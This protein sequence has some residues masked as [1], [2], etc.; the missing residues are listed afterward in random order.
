MLARSFNQITANLDRVQRDLVE[1]EKLAFVG[2][3]ASGVAHEVRTSLGVLRSSAQILEQSLYEAE[4]SEIPEL[5]GMIRD[6]VVRLSRVVDDLLTLDRPRAMHLEPTP[7]SLP[8]LRAAEFAEP[9]AKQ[10]GIHVSVERARTEAVVSCDREKPELGPVSPPMSI[11]PASHGAKAPSL[12]ASCWR[13]SST[14]GAW[15]RV[16]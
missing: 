7:L 8:L 3:L 1:A 4:G 13:N 11:V 14:S 16:I 12:S 2:E 5:V 6:E 15:I 9:Q 10:K